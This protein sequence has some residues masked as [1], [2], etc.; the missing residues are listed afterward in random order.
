MQRSGLYVGII[1]FIIYTVIVGYLF[2]EQETF[3]DGP[4]HRNKES[5]R[6]RGVARATKATRFFHHRRTAK[7]LANFFHTT[8]HH[9]RRTRVGRDA[10]RVDTMWVEGCGRTRRDATLRSFLC[11]AFFIVAVFSIEGMEKDGRMKGWTRCC[12]VSDDQQDS[13]ARMLGAG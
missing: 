13:L 4:S 12:V 2:K 6:A 1:D 11:S 3:F 8:V 7:P 9:P 5:Y 10:D